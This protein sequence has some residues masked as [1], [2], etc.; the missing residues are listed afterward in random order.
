[1]ITVI[2][3]VIVLAVGYSVLKYCVKKGCFGNNTV[4][5]TETKHALHKEILFDLGNVLRR[6]DGSEYSIDATIEPDTASCVVKERKKEDY[7]RAY[8][9]MLSKAHELSAFYVQRIENL[10]AQNRD[11]HSFSKVEKMMLKYAFMFYNETQDLLP[12]PKAFLLYAQVIE[13]HT[14]KASFFRMGQENY[15]LY[16]TAPEN[17]Q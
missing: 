1:M 7:L 14:M 8:S 9:D 15:T 16:F 13:K 3:G 2:W 5:Q 12:S 4:P 6:V 11:I 10:L 17:K